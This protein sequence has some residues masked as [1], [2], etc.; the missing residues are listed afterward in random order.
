MFLRTYIGNRRRE[1]KVK[2]MQLE[3]YMYSE[4]DGQAQTTEEQTWL[5]SSLGEEKGNLIPKNSDD[6]NQEVDFA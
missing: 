3:Q 1:D 4:N 5:E 2:L 6:Y